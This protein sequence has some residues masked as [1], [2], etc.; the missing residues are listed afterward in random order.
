MHD[1]NAHPDMNLQ[2]RAEAVAK[3][4]PGAEASHLERGD[5]TF[6]KVGDKIFLANTTMPGEP[7]VI[8]KADPAD[9]ERLRAQYPQITPG[10][11]MDKRHWITVHP[12]DQ[13][14]STLLDELVVESYRLVVGG[15]RR[16]LRPVDPA[17][18]RPE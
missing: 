12:G 6:W 17:T 14:P 10:Y 4:L 13:A 9:G 3:R 2:R 11:H 16:D 5:W 18:F 7:V 8:V 15:L 1:D